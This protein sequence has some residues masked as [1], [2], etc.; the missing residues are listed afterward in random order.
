MNTKLL[1]ALAIIFPFFTASV[2]SAQNDGPKPFYLENA[3]Q[4]LVAGVPSNG[5]NNPRCIAH[6]SF[7]D[8][9]SFEIVKDLKDSEFYFLESN[10]DWNFSE[11]TGTPGKLQMNFYLA[12]HKFNKGGVANFVILDK[13]TIV[14]PELNVTQT[15][16]LIMES[17]EV[18]FVMSGTAANSKVPLLGS[19]AA[20]VKLAACINASKNFNLLNDQK[21]V[22][23]KFKGIETPI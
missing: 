17:D 12:N 14:F 19:A 15:L 13:N 3:E 18:D 16:P 1:S 7:Q 23:P 2:A 21:K 4:W 6:L 11:T 20:M 8:G 5:Q 9:S 22:T 10:I